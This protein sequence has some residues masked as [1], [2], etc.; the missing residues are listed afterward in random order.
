M[1]R[2]LE[3]IMLIPPFW[4]VLSVF[5]LPLLLPED[6]TDIFHGHVLFWLCVMFLL[7]AV[8]AV[9]FI[10]WEIKSDTASEKIA[11]A[12]AKW[13]K[14][15]AA[16]IVVL[17]TIVFILCQISYGFWQKTGGKEI[18]RLSYEWG[19]MR[20]GLWLETLKGFLQSSFIQKLFGV[21]PDCFARYFYEDYNLNVWS[22]GMW[23]DAIY[24]NAHNEWL[25]MLV[26]EGVFGITAYAGFFI[27]SVCGFIKK[28][29]TNTAENSIAV[30]GIMSVAAYAANNFFSFGQVVSTPLVFLIVALCG[31][32]LRRH[33]AAK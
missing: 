21:G 12:I 31:N 2:F 28:Y 24:A 4:I 3:T 6:V 22:A 1:L 10:I 19:G 16:V 33:T 27:S 30:M 20:G 14:A 32:E 29:K 8:Y 23:E 7:L 17:G 25:T 9:L 18:L 26:N 11:A 13:V 15:A 5:N